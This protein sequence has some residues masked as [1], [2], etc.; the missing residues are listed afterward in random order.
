MGR[1]KLKTYGRSSQFKVRSARTKRK[2]AS[3]AGLA[4]TIATATGVA[5]LATAFAIRPQTRD[6][7]LG[8]LGDITMSGSKPSLVDQRVSVAQEV[9]T[10]YA[11]ECSRAVILSINAR[12]GQGAAWSGPLDAHSDNRLDA[13]SEREL[14]LA[15]AREQI[16]LIF[17]APPVR[18]SAIARSLYDLED[19]VEEA[20]RVIVFV[21]SDG[22]ETEAID[23]SETK[24]TS[25][26]LEEAADSL[27]RLDHS[28]WEVHFVGVNQTAD[29]GVAEVV[30]SNA[31]RFWRHL[32]DD[33][34]K[35]YST[36]LN[37]ST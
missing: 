34:L 17:R 9:L 2:R 31:E 27:P 5:V 3:R 19:M 16:E 25:D 21:F 6:C 1:N 33:S 35:S 10:Q 29:D 8:F 7:T 30:A 18:G 4:L 37:L 11:D 24:L 12:P 36:A 28:N 14:R 20:D 23:L 32:L 26:E 15:D 22:I 13:R